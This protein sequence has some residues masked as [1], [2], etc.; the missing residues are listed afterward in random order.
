ML[1][2]ES[3]RTGVGGQRV[4]L[5]IGF[6]SRKGQLDMGLSNLAARRIAG[7]SR[8]P[9][10]MKPNYETQLKSTERWTNG[11]TS[12]YLSQYESGASWEAK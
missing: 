8:R 6:G 9:N 5:G 11:I 10:G 2:F 4:S 3:G 1:Y 7:R 12:G